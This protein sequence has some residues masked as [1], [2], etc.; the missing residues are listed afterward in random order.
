MARGID[1]RRALVLALGMP[2]LAQAQ[3]NTDRPITLIVPFGPGGIADLLTKAVE[4]L[5]EM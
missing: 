3:G 1:R 4:A 2:A 5:D